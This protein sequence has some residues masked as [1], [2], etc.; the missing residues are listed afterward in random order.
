MYQV[1]CLVVLSQI[2]TGPQDWFIVNS[3]GSDDDGNFLI[4]DHNLRFNVYSS[5]TAGGA[6]EMEGKSIPAK[7]R[8]FRVRQVV[9]DTI[10]AVG[11]ANR[12]SRHSCWNRKP[13]YYAA[14]GRPFSRRWCALNTPVFPDV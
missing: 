11:H 7:V 10:G 13:L 9:S 2:L 6:P 4:L 5:S 3:V 8:A 14:N 1:R 12:V